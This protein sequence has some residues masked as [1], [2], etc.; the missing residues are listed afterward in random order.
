MPVSKTQLYIKIL[1]NRVSEAAVLQNPATQFHCKT[2]Q[3]PLS[4]HACVSSSPPLALAI[5][6]GYNEH[7]HTV[8]TELL[9]RV[10]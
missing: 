9:L 1:Q 5:K 4:K 7:L 10:K 8:E 2:L 6:V 3:V